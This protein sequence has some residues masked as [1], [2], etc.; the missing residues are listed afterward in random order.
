[1]DIDGDSKTPPKEQSKANP[2][3]PKIQS[4]SHKI[5]FANTETRKSKIEKA[6]SPV[7]NATSVNAKTR[8]TEHQADD[9]DSGDSSGEGSGAF[10]TTR[11]VQ[12]SVSTSKSRADRQ[13]ESNPTSEAPSERFTQTRPTTPRHAELSTSGKQAM[14]LYVIEYE[15][16]TVE[17]NSPLA[18]NCLTSSTVYKET[19]CLSGG[20]DLGDRSYVSLTERPLISRINTI[21]T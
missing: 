14:D 16:N 5:S 6:V 17:L 10:V 8:L 15:S 13:P 20:S 21:A 4:S 19:V 3:S 1:M 9:E 11:H 2:T 12:S 18:A 7:K